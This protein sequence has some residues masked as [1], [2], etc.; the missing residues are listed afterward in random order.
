MLIDRMNV[1][2]YMENMRKNTCTKAKRIVV[3]IG[4]TSLTHES[5]K[6]NLQNIEKLSWVLTD[7]HNQGI[8]VI[9]VSSGAIAVGAQRLNLKERPRDVKGKQASS[10]VGQAILM[11]IYENCFLRYN[12][13][14]AQ[15]LLTK[16]SLDDE[17]R[18]QYAKD[19]FEKL[20]IWDVIPIVN[21]NDTVAIDELGFSDNDNLSSE[22]AVLMESDILIILSDIDGLYD[23]DPN[24]YK[25]AKRIE[26]ENIFAPYLEEIAG[27]SA[28]ALG[29]GGM[30]SKIT[31]AKRAASKNINTVIAKGSDPTI[32]FN[33]LQGK[34]VGTLLYVP[35][36]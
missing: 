19:T 17:K 23:A 31:A 1:G 27:G 15:I 18:R 11:Q 20:L 16:D 4:T 30:Y 12:Q 21:E 6:L 5:G 7:I 22:I 10:A 29:T 36:K 13:N 3:K 2:A 33:I 28:S 35:E 9:L 25:N 24:I 32:L 14:V 26:K 8:D 34:N